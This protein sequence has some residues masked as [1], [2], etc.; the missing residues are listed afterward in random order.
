MILLF[1]GVILA[2][3][4]INQRPWASEL[5][6]EDQ[7]VI[8]IPP[9][10]YL[11][12]YLYAEHPYYLIDRTIIYKPLRLYSDY[13]WDIESGIKIYDLK[14]NIILDSV[15]TPDFESQYVAVIASGSLLILLYKLFV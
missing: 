4:I 9:H 6:S 7:I 10:T 8:K 1:Y 2:L 13:E 3:K 12:S 15:N 5:I 14:G 11:S